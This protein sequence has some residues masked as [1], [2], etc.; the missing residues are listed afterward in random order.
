MCVSL[1]VVVGRLPP[2]PPLPS[3]CVTRSWLGL[4]FS[5]SPGGGGTYPSS[6]NGGGRQTLVL[7][8]VRFAVVLGA[9][10]LNLQPLHADLE[11]IHGLD[12]S[13]RRH[14]IVIADEP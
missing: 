12:G 10:Q 1:R 8:S 13:L 11:T 14:R 6:A 7:S 9:L 3:H 5:F 2:P 4:F